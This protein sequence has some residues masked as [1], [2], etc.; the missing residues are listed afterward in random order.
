MNLS[1]IIQGWSNLTFPKEEA[2]QFLQSLEEQRLY[3]CRNC[4]YGHKEI[5][6]TS[7]CGHCGCFLRA[8]ARCVDCSCPIGKWNAVGDSQQDE[9]IQ[10]LAN[11]EL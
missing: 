1:H 10:T 5:N 6:I 7:T 11:D 8:K 4:E 2:K 3:F 9:T